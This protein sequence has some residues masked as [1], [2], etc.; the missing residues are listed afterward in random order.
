MTV[1]S[2]NIFPKV[3]LDGLTSDP[4][5][6]SNDNWKLY[7]KVDGVYARSSNTIVGPFTDA[8]GSGAPSDAQYVV[9]AANGDLSAEIVVTTPAT[10]GIIPKF[11]RKTADETVNNSAVFQDDDAL[12]LAV[13]ASEVWW[14]EANIYFDSGTTPDF[15]VQWTAP[16]GATVYVSETGFD[17]ASAA[18]NDATVS[19]ASASRTHT[20]TGAGT[21]RHTRQ[22]GIIANGVNAGNLQ[23][24]WAQNTQNSSD[25]KVLANST[26]MA[27]KLA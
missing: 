15:K 20:G 12:L 25:T 7:S 17:A 19:A 18:Y 4:A 23:L 3:L 8:A 22:K 10:G 14:F 16:V 5:A 11:V 24:Q 27:F 2:D 6:P 21:V 1:G 9:A 13:G 26:I